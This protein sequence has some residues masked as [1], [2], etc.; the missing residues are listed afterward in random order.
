ME[1]ASEKPPAL[2]Y[3][4]IEEFN[5][6]QFFQC[7]ETLEDLWNEERRELRRFY[8]GI[9]QIGVGYYKI[10][11]RPNYRGALSLLQSG[12][13]LLVGFEP[14]LFEIDV[15]ELI[16]VARQAREQLLELGPDRFLTFDR[17]QIPL[18]GRPQP[19]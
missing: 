7:H 16:G 6:R 14:A 4:A 13:E 8:Q 12:A 9:L 18:I 2:F 11:G 3:Q 17:R 10:I 5:A 1:W 19:N 15:S